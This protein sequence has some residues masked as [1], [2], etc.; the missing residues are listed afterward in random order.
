MDGFDLADSTHWL[1]IR[2]ATTELYDFAQRQAGQP[3]W[4]LVIANAV[5]DLLDLAR[6]V[7]AIVGL[8]APGGLLYLTINFDG[9]T[10]FQPT[11]DRAF[12][13]LVEAR[14]HLTM[15][16]RLTAGRPSGD[17]Y[18]GRRLLVELPAA[19]GQLLAAGSSDWVVFPQA[20]GYP[21][22]EAY[23]LRSIIATVYR[24]L[25]DDM[26]LDQTRLAAWIARRQGQI[27]RG[28]LIYIAHQLDLLARR[29]A[30]P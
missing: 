1:T 7:P 29:D 28:E 27:E 17:S 10:I 21:A 8:T 5:L 22:D 19:G 9:G 23:F 30:R 12:D 4:Q 18:T 24:A 20:G 11:I 26:A 13:A 6:A 16:R 25:R 14:Y 15:D 3:G 2:L